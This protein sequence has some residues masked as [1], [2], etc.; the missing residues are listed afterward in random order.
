MLCMRIKLNEPVV[1]V[2]VEVSSPT[3]ENPLSHFEVA[4]IPLLFSSLQS[5]LTANLLHL[6]Q[7][8]GASLLP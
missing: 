2:I 7:Y 8:H 6:C 4:R 3:A 1:E 5:F